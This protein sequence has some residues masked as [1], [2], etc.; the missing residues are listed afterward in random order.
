MKLKLFFQGILF[1][2]IISILIAFYYV[3]LQNKNEKNLISKEDDLILDNEV[4]NELINIEY[5]SIDAE[6]N[7][8]YINAEKAIIEFKDQSGIDNESEVS[9]NGVISVINLKEKGIINIYSDY[10]IYNKLNHDTL[11]YDNVKVEYLGNS[12]SADNLDLIFSKKISRIYNNV[13]YK[14]NKLNLNTDKAIIDM[15]SGDIKLEMNEKNKKVKL[16]SKYEY[17]N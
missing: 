7:T 15:V 9:L 10:A 5:N 12:I 8:F 16:I 17:I 2:S 3:F 6:G 4:S 1:I 14:N 11:F 13:V